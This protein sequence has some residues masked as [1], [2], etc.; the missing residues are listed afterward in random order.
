MRGRVGRAKR[1]A[2]PMF[3]PA[4]C[5]SLYLL[6]RFPSRI[7]IQV[8]V[9]HRC[10]S[11][12][13]NVAQRRADRMVGGTLFFHVVGTIADGYGGRRCRSFSYCDRVYTRRR[14][15]AVT[16]APPTCFPS[17]LAADQQWQTPEVTATYWPRKAGYDTGRERAFAD[18]Y[19]VCRCM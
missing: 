12:P 5:M 14:M 16:E 3:V 10:S 2:T 7:Q 13:F 4:Y 6:F 1:D 19:G 11:G 8:Q 9:Q 18:Y 17:A 15:Y